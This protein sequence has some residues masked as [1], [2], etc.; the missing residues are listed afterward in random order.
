MQNLVRLL[1]LIVCLGSASLAA[2]QAS[3]AAGKT[4]E[5]G[6]WSISAYTDDQTKRLDH[7]AANLNNGGSVTLIYS[8]NTRLA[9]GLGFSSPAWNFTKG[10]TFDIFLTIGDQDYPRLRAAAT[11]SQIVEVQPNDQIALFEALRRRVQLQAHAGGLSFKF[12][13]D[14]NGEVLSA[15]LQCAAPQKMPAHNV[16]LIS[17]LQAACTSRQCSPANEAA[18]RAEATE[19]A[20]NY[21]ADSGIRGPQILAPNESPDLHGD[22]VWKAGPVTGAISVLTPDTFSRIDDIP[23]RIVASDAQACRGDF[24]AGTAIELAGQSRLDRVLTSC[25]SMPNST[26]IFY[27]A[28][29]RR[30][31]GFYLFATLSSGIERFDSPPQAAQAVDA[32]IRAVVS[33]SLPK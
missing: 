9:W 31:G 15:L 17:P 21:F 12:D 18:K 30:Q 20:M 13:L 24:F 19:I 4:I 5:V 8:V 10:D 3:A 25:Q 11:S 28:I 27:F 6:N 16:K 22:L 29:P 26:S 23:S 14:G 32:S 2:P 33:K 7:C 1:A